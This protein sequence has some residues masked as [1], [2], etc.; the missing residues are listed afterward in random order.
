[1]KT[2]RTFS[3]TIWETKKEAR[4]PSDENVTDNRTKKIKKAVLV[5]IVIEQ[6]FHRVKMPVYRQSVRQNGDLPNT[7]GQLAAE[8]SESG[9]TGLQRG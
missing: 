2:I 7:G 6:A 8:I 4:H 9:N 5:I 1:M 3:A